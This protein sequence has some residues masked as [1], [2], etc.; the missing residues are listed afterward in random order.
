MQSILPDLESEAAVLS[1]A[2]PEFDA[3]M[4]GLRAARP[5]RD[6][7][8][9]AAAEDLEGGRV[10]EAKR[11]LSKVLDQRP[12]S[13]DALDLMAEIAGREGRHGEAERLLARCVE[14]S[15]S[16]ALYRYH[17]VL[18]LD[19][20]GRLDSAIAETGILIEQSPRNPVFRNLKASLLKQ[21]GNY[22]EAVSWYR[23]LAEDCPRASYVWNALGA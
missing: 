20:L 18:A 1:S 12:R 13:P 16:I 10:T 21:I 2:A 8:L 23:G 19:R 15:P 11:A 4:A 5:L 7:R 6:K 17:Y 3:A 9:A 14:A 22:G